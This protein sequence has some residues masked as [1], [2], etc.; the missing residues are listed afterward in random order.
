MSSGPA[1]SRMNG[2]MDSATGEPSSG[3]STRL[4]M[5]S[6][7]LSLL[8]LGLGLRGWDVSSPVPRWCAT[9]LPG[10]IG[11]DRLE[12]RGV[13][14]HASA[15]GWGSPSPPAAANPRRHARGRP[16]RGPAR[17]GRGPAGYGLTYEQI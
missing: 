7:P 1:M 15:L 9:G 17:A 8:D 2:M 6:L 10:A 14:R 16:R 3:T 11:G 12:K 5:T 13:G 4:Y